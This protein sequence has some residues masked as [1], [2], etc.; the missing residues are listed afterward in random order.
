MRGVD[1]DPPRLIAFL[2][3]PLLARFVAMTFL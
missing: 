3:L 2:R 1:G